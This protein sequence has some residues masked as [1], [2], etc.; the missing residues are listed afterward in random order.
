MP[1][2]STREMAA[3]YQYEAIEIKETSH[4]LDGLF[5]A[6]AWVCFEM[7]ARRIAVEDIAD[8]LGLKEATAY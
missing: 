2:E 8:I 5:R 1:A 6:K 7:A 3:R 4:R